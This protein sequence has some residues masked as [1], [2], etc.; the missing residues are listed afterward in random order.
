[1]AD[2]DA[3]V[4]NLLQRFRERWRLVTVGLLAAAF[5]AVNVVA[6]RHA[7][8]M[9]RFVRSG[10]RTAA[11]EKL[12]ALAKARVLLT[13]VTLTRPEN[14]RTPKEVGLEFQT[15]RFAGAKGIQLEAWFVSANSASNGVVLLFHGYG[16]SKES[17]LSPA[18]EFQALG[19]DTLLVD[20]HGSGGSAGDTTSAGWHEAEDVA[21]AFAEAAKLAPRKPRV[22]YGVSMGAAACLRAIHANGVKPDALILECPFDRM[23]T[24]V[25]HRFH[26]MRLPSFPF[27]ELLVFWGGQSGGFNAFAH[28]PVDY[29]P[30]VHCSTLMMHGAK[31]PR[32]SVREVER[33]YEKLGGGKAL[34]IFPKLGHQSYVE[35]DVN[36]W[37]E[38]VK[39]QLTLVSATPR[40]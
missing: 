15:V 40:P 26:A 20:F 29:A 16:A 35:S 38:Q 6:W 39:G 5:V 10:E 7:R 13:G 22:L 23:L 9:S 2:S 14:R 25:Q 8:A 18:I 24:T 11:P 21:A 1:M 27:A 19:W 31:D 3:E 4:K 33:I 37:R 36:A 12:G 28:N 34:V 17:L 32:V 30:A